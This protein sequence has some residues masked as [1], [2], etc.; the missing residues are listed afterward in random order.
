MRSGFRF[1]P[2]ARGCAPTLCLTLVLALVLA[3]PVCAG[4][5]IVGGT[6]SSGPLAQLLFEA[7]RKQAP[8]HSLRLISP[9]L[10]TNGALRALE[11]NRVHLV[12]AGRPLAKEELARFGQHFDLADTPFVMASRDGQR[13]GGFSLDELAQVYEGR[14]TTWGDGAPIRLV[15]RGAFESDT[16]LLKDMSGALA[17]AMEVAKNRPGMAGAVNDLETVTVLT[18]TR[19]ALGPTTLGLLTSLNVRLQVFALNGAAPSLANLKSGKYP[20]RKRLTVV[21]PQQP[22]PEATAFAAFLRSAKA[23]ELLL[24][25]DYLPL[26]P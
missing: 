15:L 21:L 16:L 18:G 7:Y 26:T 2:I 14:L 6:G 24:R 10:G 17:Q 11:Q 4:E 19:G 25:N 3:A 23:R 20:W 13:P 1:R 22:S 9:P 8:E 5:L 12:L